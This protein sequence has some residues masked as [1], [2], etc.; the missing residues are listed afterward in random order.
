MNPLRS[1]YSPVLQKEDMFSSLKKATEL[2]NMSILQ[3][4]LVLDVD[5]RGGMFQI[6]RGGN[7]GGNNLVSS[8]MTLKVR[9]I[10]N[11]YNMSDGNIDGY[12][13]ADEYFVLPLLSTNRQEI[14][15]RGEYVMIIFDRPFTQST[16]VIG[17]WISKASDFY[18][19]DSR[20]PFKRS[21][22]RQGKEI[23]HSDAVIYSGA[24]PESIDKDYDIKP[25]WDYEPYPDRIRLKAGDVYD[26]GRSNT[27]LIHT[28]G[29]HE[30]AEKRGYIELGTEY[31]YIESLKKLKEWSWDVEHSQA[32]IDEYQ[33]ILNN[34]NKKYLDNFMKRSSWEFLNSSGSRI[35]L[36]TKENIDARLWHKDTEKDWTGKF[37]N[38]QKVFDKNFRDDGTGENCGKEIEGT[39]DEKKPIH[40]KIDFE[41]QHGD[42]LE[43]IGNE[44][45]GIKIDEFMA[46]MYLEAQN[47]RMIA[48]DGG[49]VNHMVLGEMMVRWM[50]RFGE[51]VLHMMRTEDILR[52]RLNKL[53]KD[54]MEHMH[55]VVCGSTLQPLGS[56]DSNVFVSRFPYHKGTTNGDVAGD[57]AEFEQSGSDSIDMSIKDRITDE[58]KNVEALLKQ[59]PEVLSKTHAIN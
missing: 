15:E 57:D 7:N 37:G 31:E 2:G 47:F 51:V 54:F 21:E 55:M 32:E 59:L 40:D 3:T 50:M 1:Q 25:N 38:V 16:S 10:T 9:L 28:F 24:R 35:I 48:R 6:N 29:A 4:A 19:K 14:P 41:T 22:A 8:P 26:R 18:T 20:S 34:H 39:K 11:H 17:Y 53:S 42:V 30:Q 44:R 46:T 58:R 23:T 33:A 12:I 43:V 49:D 52:D 36:A 13:D 45:E 27:M 56:P 5:R